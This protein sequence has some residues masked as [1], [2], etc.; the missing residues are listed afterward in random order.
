ME[1]QVQ[2]IEMPPHQGQNKC[3]QEINDNTH[4]LECGAEKVLTD[5]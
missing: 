5:Q 4:W 3:H 1:M 2:S